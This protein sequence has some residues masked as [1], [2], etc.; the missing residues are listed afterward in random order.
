MCLEERPNKTLVV[1]L[2]QLLELFSIILVNNLFFRATENM[3]VTD[4]NSNL[5]LLHAT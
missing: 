4:R 2:F 1:Y 5:Q 3:D